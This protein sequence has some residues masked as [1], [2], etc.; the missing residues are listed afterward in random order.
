M[1][2]HDDALNA[3]QVTMMIENSVANQHFKLLK[4]DIFESVS[5]P[6]CINIEALLITSSFSMH[7]LLGKKISLIVDFYFVEKYFH[8][9]VFEY[10]CLE[11]GFSPH[12][13]L[14]ITIKPW[15]CLLHY[16]NAYR[17]YQD[18]TVID[19]IRQLF[20]EKEFFDFKFYCSKPYERKNYIFQYGESCYDFVQRLLKHEGIFYFFRYESNRHILCFSDEACCSLS[21]VDVNYAVHDMIEVVNNHENNDYSHYFLVYADDFLSHVGRR[22]QN[23]IIWCNHYQFYIRHHFFSKEQSFVFQAGTQLVAI[24]DLK[25]PSQC[26]LNTLPTCQS[27]F[28]MEKK[29][30]V[31]NNRHIIRFAWENKKT[32][33]QSYCVAK[34][35]YLLTANSYG[36]IWHASYGDEMLLAFLQG[37]GTP[38]LLGGA[39]KKNSMACLSDYSLNFCNS[40]KLKCYSDTV[41]Q[42]CFN[43]V[44]SAMCLDLKTIGKI[45]WEINNDYLQVALNEVYT[46]SADIL[47]CAKQTYLSLLA[48]KI[49]LIAS[50]STIELLDN[51]KLSSPEKIFLLS[52]SDSQR[53]AVST[54]G[55]Q[56]ICLNHQHQPLAIAGGSHNVSVNQK[57]LARV[58]DLTPCSHSKNNSIVTGV[59][60][61]HVNGKALAYVM[62][63]TQH[64][65]KILSGDNGVMAN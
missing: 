60:T 63:K 22:C 42:L 57:A 46:S 32:I 65:G 62:S 13:K 41:H 18:V 45:L 39:Y 36:V 55:D 6:F 48:R 11:D 33:D 31:Q 61:I 9:L 52:N 17:V 25:F 14:V 1:M 34:Q 15:F 19:V 12:S 56:H 7:S 50:G 30:S 27:A 58:G 5:Q 59:D 38:I 3:D 16:S 51:A 10:R 43:D 8:G 47:F 29:G 35:S 2:E 23:H 64:Q 21:T 4:L 26:E 40:I 49:S 28:Y 24:S 44:P 37:C 20:K 53:Y 54:I